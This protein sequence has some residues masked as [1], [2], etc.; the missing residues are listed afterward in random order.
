MPF[1][2]KS[3]YAAGATLPE[4]V[5][6]VADLVAINSPHETPLLDALGD[7][8]RSARSTM[9]EWLE[10]KLLPNTDICTALD[11]GTDVMTVANAAASCTT[12]RRSSPA[13]SRSADRNWPSVSSACATN[14]TIKRRCASASFCASSRTA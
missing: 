4:I 7:P 10:D 2:G 1:T 11:T 6:D 3:T 14:W 13:P 8:A 9:H 5:E 12:S